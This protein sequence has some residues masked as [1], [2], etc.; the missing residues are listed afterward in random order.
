MNRVLSLTGRRLLA[1]AG[2]LAMAVAGMVTLSASPASAHSQAEAIAAACGSGYGIVSDGTRAVT[3]P[4]GTVY[5]YVHLAYN[6]SNGN[7][8]VVTR[9]T[10]YHGTPTRTRAQIG[11]QQANGSIVTYDDAGDFSHY[12]NVIRFASGRCVTYFGWIWST[13][14]GGN[15]TLAS[16]GRTTLGNCG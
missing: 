16:G 13:P 15:G 7:N 14:T 2:A 6:S 12:A 10:S 3:T 5:G 8:C 11:V 4:S 1:T 9:K